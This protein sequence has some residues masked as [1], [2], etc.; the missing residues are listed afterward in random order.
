M[1]QSTEVT[2]YRP[3]WVEIS[4]S[5][6]CMSLALQW[7]SSITL[8]AFSPFGTR[9]ENRIPGLFA[10]FQNGKITQGSIAIQKNGEHRKFNDADGLYYW[11]PRDTAVEPSREDKIRMVLEANQL[12]VQHI[13]LQQ[14][15]LESSQDL[16]YYLVP[17][18]P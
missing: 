15:G 11:A 18:R 6:H 9:V 17:D 12:F 10:D 16:G 1:S 4:H 7:R 13:S 14:E 5:L 8:Q 3:Q 2:E